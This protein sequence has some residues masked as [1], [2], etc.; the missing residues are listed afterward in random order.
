[1]SPPQPLGAEE[2]LEERDTPGPKT[3]VRVGISEQG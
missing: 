3:L 2:A 1:M